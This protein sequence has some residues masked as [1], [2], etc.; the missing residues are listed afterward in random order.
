MDLL[1][2]AERIASMDRSPLEFNAEACLHSLDKYASCEACYDICP[3]DAIQAGKPPSFDNEQCQTCLA[4]LPACPV[5]A[6]TAVD[7]VPALLNSVVRS[8]RKTIELVCQV[9]AKIEAGPRQSDLAIRV[10]GCLASLGIGTYLLLVAME[11]ENIILR[12]DACDQCP[13]VSLKIHIEKQLSIARKILTPSGRADRLQSITDLSAMEKHERPVWI[14]ENP[15][16]SRRDL[17]RITSYMALPQVLQ[18]LS[19]GQRQI[20]N[21]RLSQDRRR[22]LAAVAHLANPDQQDEVAV[23]D[24][25]GFATLT[26]SDACTACGVCARACPCGAI[27]FNHSHDKKFQ[28][29]FTPQAC[30]VC[31]ICVNICQP[32]AI[33]LD[34]KPSF[35]DVFGSRSSKLLHEG[36]LTRCK[37]CHVLMAAKPG[38]NLCAICEFRQK[39]P[40]G[41]ALPPGYKGPFKIPKPDEGSR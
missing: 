11:I 33:T 29:S 25:T 34:P 4:C 6:Y 22:V 26:I 19:S 41:S 38:I 9:H 1:T 21:D 24:E 28:L 13:W 14:A 12:M 40:F 35:K 39:N 32:D 23:L 27:T 30:I 16:L 3:V 8:N 2:I 17:F 36:E 7:N 18:S 10:R 5:G 37:N 20:G 15:P 31:E